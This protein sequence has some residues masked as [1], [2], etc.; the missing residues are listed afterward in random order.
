MANGRSSRIARAHRVLDRLAADKKKTVFAVSLFAVMGFMWFRLLAG[1]GP[2]PV[3]ADPGTGQEQAAPQKAPRNICYLT[4]P[5]VQGR[6]DYINRDFFAARDWECFRQ[7]RGS[8][9]QGPGAEVRA[10]VPD[11]AREVAARVAQK[12]ELVAILGD[13]TPRAFINDRLLRV[14]ERLTVRDGPDLCEFEVLHI[15]EDSV[16]VGCNG[17]RLTLKLTEHVD[18]TK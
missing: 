5:S 15:Y 13:G 18:V 10:P 9:Q 3:S 8:Q 4:L 7:N 17:T 11:P 16:L 1:R 14:G 12:I 6:N 2:G